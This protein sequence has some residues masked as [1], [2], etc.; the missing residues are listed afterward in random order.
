MILLNYSNV[1]IYT[2][3][4]HSETFLRTYNTHLVSKVKKYSLTYLN[5]QCTNSIFKI[6]QFYF[7]KMIHNLNNLIFMKTNSF[8]S[9]VI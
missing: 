5:Q 3:G 9:K 8:Q 6:D 2:F 1:P 4:Y 7:V